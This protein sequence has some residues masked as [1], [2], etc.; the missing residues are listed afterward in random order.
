MKNV[1]SCCSH[2]LK[3][4]SIIFIFLPC[5]QEVLILQQVLAK[6]SKQTTDKYGIG[7]WADPFVIAAGK[8]FRI[9]II[10]EE[11]RGTPDS[12]RSIATQMQV[13]QIRLVKFFEDQGW[14]FTG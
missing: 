1:T 6:Y 9:T 7:L 13:D 8:H 3:G 14:S 4:N 2:S 5:E 11:S 12:I 10:H